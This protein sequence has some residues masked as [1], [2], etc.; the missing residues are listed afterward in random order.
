MDRDGGRMTEEIRT[1]IT[2]I[3]G[4]LARENQITATEQIRMLELLKSEQN[5]G[6]SPVLPGEK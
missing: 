1:I 2:R 4:I 6:C 3:I 5:E